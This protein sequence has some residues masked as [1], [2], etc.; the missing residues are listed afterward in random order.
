MD[1]GEFI[2]HPPFPSLER[3]LGLGDLWVIVDPWLWLFLGG[4]LL[5]RPGGVVGTG[6]GSWE[7]HRGLYRPVRAGRPRG[8]SDRLG[9]RSPGDPRRLPRRS[10]QSGDG[11]RSARAG[12][13]LVVVYAALCSVSHHAALGRVRTEGRRAWRRAR[14]D[15]RRVATPRR[16]VP[17]GGIIADASTV[18]PTGPSPALAVRG[19]TRPRW[20]PSSRAGRPRRHSPAGELRRRR[21]PRVLPLPRSPPSRW[22]Q[23]AAGRRGARRALYQEGTRLR[24]SRGTPGQERRADRRSEGVPLRAWPRRGAA[25]AHPI[26]V[27]GL[28]RHQG[29]ASSDLG[30]DQV[31]VDV[32]RGATYGSAAGG[33]TV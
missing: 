13:G 21:H 33:A 26:A 14:A 5:S 17:L 19:R 9:R 23:A 1:A 2:R 18:P 27:E 25:S 16:S 31:Q 12:L 28:D 20:R 7:R 15:G 22:I 8:L 29:N 11:S 10:G 30:R 6:S 32:R 3:P 4:G 24:R